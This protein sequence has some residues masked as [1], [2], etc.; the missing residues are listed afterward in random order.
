MIYLLSELE[1]LFHTSAFLNRVVTLGG[2][3]PII[4]LLVPSH[5]NTARHTVKTVNAYWIKEIRLVGLRK[6]NEGR[7]N[8]SV[9]ILFWFFFFNTKN[10]VSER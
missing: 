1:L 2:K 9:G 4:F 6:Q 7:R 3:V 5:L 8:P 10:Y